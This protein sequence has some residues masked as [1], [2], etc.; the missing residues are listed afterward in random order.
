MQTEDLILAN[1]IHNEDYARKVLPYLEE[2]Y[3]H[4]PADKVVFNL[5]KAY[6]D[7]YNSFPSKEALFIELQNVDGLNEGVYKASQAKIGVYERTEDKEVKWLV[8]TTEKFCQDKALHNGILESIRI[9]DGGSKRGKGEIPELLQKALG[10]S[11]DTSVGHSYFDD[12]EDRFDFYH[13]KE[14]KVST[15]LHYLDLVMDGGPPGKTLNVIMAPTGVG[16]SLVMGHLAQHSMM[17]GKNV[18]YITLELADKQIG[19]RIDANILDT[20]ISDVGKKTDKQSFGKKLNSFRTKTIGALEI[21]EYPATACSA[22]TIRNLLNELKLKK[23]FVPDVIFLDY[24]NLCASSRI[25]M[26]GTVNS[27]GYIKA[28]AEEIRGVAQEFDVPIWTATQ[29]NRSGWNNTD[30][31]LDNTSESFGLPMTADFMIAVMLPPD[32]EGMDQYLFKQLKNRYGDVNRYKRFVVGVD[33]PKMRLYD[34]EQSGQEDLGG[35]VSAKQDDQTSK[36][37]MDKFSDW[38]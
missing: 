7:K 31:D 11:F 18:L 13:R 4:D 35:D 5:T 22:H 29:T 26:G 19:K 23:K 25:K 36:F 17:E 9:L 32:M 16:K 34:V 1:L 3:F 8:D 33:K 21:V 10:V 30:I 37:D 6:V 12:W 24:L 27:F 14:V 2:D 15:G 28:V 20:L 38:K